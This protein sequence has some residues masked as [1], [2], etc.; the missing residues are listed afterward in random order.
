LN[1]PTPNQ[2]TNQPTNQPSLD[3][4]S[5][6]HISITELANYAFEWQLWFF[7]YENK[8]TVSAYSMQWWP[9]VQISMTA[10]LWVKQSPLIFRNKLKYPSCCAWQQL[11]FS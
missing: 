5:V 2:P 10:T 4:T 6:N 8:S 7:V 9:E 3:L 1:G 11:Q